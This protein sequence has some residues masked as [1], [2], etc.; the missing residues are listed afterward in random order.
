M[1]VVF[2]F[3]LPDRSTLLPLSVKAL[4]PPGKVRPANAVSAVKSLLS[5]VWPLL[6]KVSESPPS[7]GALPPVQLPG[8]LQLA[9]TA[10]VQVSL[11][12]RA[13]RAGPSR[14]DEARRVW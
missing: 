3:V 2:A 11:A 5:V 7:G 12:A 8:L 6:A 14:T 1:P 10:P 13:E 4:A 9:F